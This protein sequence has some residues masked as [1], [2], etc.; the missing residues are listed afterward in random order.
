M[1]E[2]SLHSKYFLGVEDKQGIRQIPFLPSWS[3]VLVME[4]EKKE[5]K[6][7]SDIISGCV[8]CHEEK[9]SIIKG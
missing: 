2:S 5:D 4:T 7:L 9:E 8:K 6:N 3:S 1:I